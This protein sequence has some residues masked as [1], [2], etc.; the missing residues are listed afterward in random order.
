[1]YGGVL[2]AY[3]TA[4]MKLHL[5][6]ILSSALLLLSSCGGADADADIEGIKADMRGSMEEMISVLDGIEATED[7][8]AAK[9]KLEAIVAKHKELKARMDDA[10]SGRPAAE[11][12]AAVADMK[13]DADL[14][15]R[16]AEATVK[17]SQVDGG[18]TIIVPI[19][20]DIGK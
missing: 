3:A 15:T 8:D 10:F 5:A 4:K 19:L 1:M 6:A 2:G 18:L 7:L 13:N 20:R 12:E 9:S 16:F 11:R 17:A 14:A